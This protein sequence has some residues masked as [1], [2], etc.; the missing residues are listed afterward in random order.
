MGLAGP[1]G[2]QGETGA[3]GPRGLTGPPGTAAVAEEQHQLP[4]VY[5]SYQRY[6]EPP[7]PPPPPSGLVLD[8]SSSPPHSSYSTTGPSAT[9][10]QFEPVQTQYGTL[11]HSLPPPPPP[12]GGIVPPPQP[13]RPPPSFKTSSSSI[14][15][16]I[17]QIEDFPPFF[18]IKREVVQDGGAAVVAEQS[19]RTFQES[20]SAPLSLKEFSQQQAPPSGASVED[21]EGHMTAPQERGIAIDPTELANA[22]RRHDQ[23]AGGIAG[24]PRRPNSKMEEIRVESPPISQEVLGDSHNPLPIKKA[25]KKQVEADIRKVI[26]QIGKKQG[27]QQDNKMAPS[28]STSGRY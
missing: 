6:D 1:P 3:A 4:A 20:S 28:S 17:N 11:Q 15:N 7:P 22:F 8:L 9:S 5:Q 19:E 26:L 14:N 23:A 25:N 16:N 12:F 13:P 2:Q 27:Q 18:P 10:L 21:D 24:P